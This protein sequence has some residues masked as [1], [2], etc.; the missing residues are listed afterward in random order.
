MAINNQI[1]AYNFPQ[2]VICQLFRD[3][4]AGRPGCITHIGLDTFVDPEI[5]G[6][7]INTVSTE[8]LVERVTLG[9]KTYLWYKALPIHVGLIRATAADPHGN[10]ITNKEAIIGEVLPIAQAAHNSGGIVIAQVQE[11]LDEPLSPQRVNVPRHPHRPH[12]P[13]PTRPTP[14]NLRRTLQPPILPTRATPRPRH[15]AHPKN[16]PRP[17]T[18]HRRSSL[19]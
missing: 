5:N 16:A 15:L 8:P 7:R 17:K 2:G 4:A 11:L 18:N 1:Q 14:P 12:R 6:G 9:Q 3:I 19:P 10:L 13:G